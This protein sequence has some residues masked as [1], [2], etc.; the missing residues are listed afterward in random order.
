MTYSVNGRIKTLG[1]DTLIYGL[2]RILQK[3]VAFLL[4]PIYTRVLSPYAYGAQ[5][6]IFS[7]VAILSYLL[8]LGLDSGTARTYYDTDNPAEKKDIL[9]TFLFSQV[10][11]SIPICLVVSLAAK[12]IAQ[13]LFR[14]STLAIYLV[15]GVVS[16][17]FTLISNV[18]LMALRVTFRPREY[19]RITILSVLVQAIASI[20]FVVIFRFDVLGVF[21]AHLITAIF[22]AFI[23]L[24]LTHKQYHHGFSRLWLKRMLA[25]GA[26]LVPASLSIWILNYSNRYFLV[27]FASLEDVGMLAVGNKISSILAMLISAFQVA[28]GPFAYSL[29]D[30]FS[31]ARKTYSKVLTYFLVVTLSATTV[32][33]LFSRELILLLSTSDYAGS[34]RVVPYL[35]LS[36]VLW[37]MSVIVGI[38]YSIRNKSYH[39][40]IAALLGA[41]INIVLNIILIPSWGLIGAAASALFG[42]ILTVTYSTFISQ[43]NF[44]VDYDF[45]KIAVITV[46]T[47]LTIITGLSFDYFFSSRIVFSLIIKIGFLCIYG[48][49]LFITHSIEMAEIRMFFQFIVTLIPKNF[50]IH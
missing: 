31:L 39:T 18:A 5:D 2:G 38:G 36:S 7:A 13:L 9:S 15:L 33:S 34:A 12:P 22:R 41:V 47:L 1:Q 23:G 50:F 20:V 28:W 8:V 48:V 42:N 17:P 29:I 43:K 44:Y 11:I 4:F 10:M 32:I 21:L 37:G 14:D 30:N 46:I 26:P 27:R 40:T 19:T 24:I 3:I 35:A 6:L 16:L 49:L 25:F 45:R